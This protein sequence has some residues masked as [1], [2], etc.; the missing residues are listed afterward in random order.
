MLYYQDRNDRRLLMKL[1]DDNRLHYV[2]KA[3]LRRDKKR[4][5]KVRKLINN[6]RIKTAED[7]YR[8]ALIYQHNRPPEGCSMAYILALQADK[9]GY[10]PKANEMHPLWLAAAAIDRW[11]V[12]F[13]RPQYFGTQWMK[14]NEGMRIRRPVDPIIT[15]EERKKWHV[16]PLQELN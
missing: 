1:A 12:S 13:N 3:V 14:N 11:L 8:A 15:D 4:L 9:M 6:A 5:K 10:R 2:R 7:Y 16:P